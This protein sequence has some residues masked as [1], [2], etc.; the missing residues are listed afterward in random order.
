MESNL[1]ELKTKRQ[2][3]LNSLIEISKTWDGTWEMGLELIESWDEDFRCLQDLD[4]RIRKVDDSY[5]QTY[6]KA[7]ENFMSIYS[8]ILKV[9]DGERNSA[10]KGLKD[11]QIGKKKGKAYIVSPVSSSLFVDKDI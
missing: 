9:L 8:R 5:D 7:L 11:I 6:H 3:I 10:L 4:F 1:K 2:E